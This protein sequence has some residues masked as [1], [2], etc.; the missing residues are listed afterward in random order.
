MSKLKILKEYHKIKYMDEVEDVDY[1]TNCYYCTKVIDKVLYFEVY[2]E[3]KLL[4]L[5]FKTFN[6]ILK[7]DGDIIYGKQFTIVLYQL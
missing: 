6:L 7:L 3:D 2:N 1:Y 5:I 4:G